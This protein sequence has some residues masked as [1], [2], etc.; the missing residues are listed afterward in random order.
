M[1][2]NRHCEHTKLKCFIAQ[3]NKGMFVFNF[4]IFFIINKIISDNFL[5]CY[6]VLLT[7]VQLNIKL[8]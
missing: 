4:K 1:K 7:V 8:L 6:I 3:I 2:S 5:N